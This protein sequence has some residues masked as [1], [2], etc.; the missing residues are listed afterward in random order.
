LHGA[1]LGGLLWRCILVHA[2]ATA[3]PAGDAVVDA[4]EFA[5][6]LSS[7]KLAMGANSYIY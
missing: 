6:E 2:G 3:G 5:L 4:E 1:Q 7:E